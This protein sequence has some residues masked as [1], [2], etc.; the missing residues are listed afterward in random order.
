MPKLT[1]S[2]VKSVALPPGKN[3]L[4]F[5]DDELT[6]F[7]LRLSAR[8]K[9]F[10]IQ[11]R[12]GRRVLKRKIG[13]YG[14]LTVDQARKG[15]LLLKAQLLDGKD[16]YQERKQGP[17]NATLEHLFDEY[18]KE[19]RHRSATLRSIE[20]AKKSFGTLEGQAFRTKPDGRSLDRIDVVKVTLPSWLKRSYR[21]ITQDEVL[22]RFDIVTRMLPKR[23]LSKVPRPI[24]RTANQHFKY[25]QA[26]YNYAISKYRL[27]PTAFVNPVAILKTARR[28]DRMNRRS[29]FLD[30][31]KP[32][33]AKWWWACESVEPRVVS[34]YILFSLVTASRS[35]ESAT[36]RWQDVDLEKARMIFRNTKNGQDYMFPIAPL[37]RAILERRL[38]EKMNDFVFGYADSRTG[39]VVCPPHHHI[40]VIRAECGEEWSMHDLRRTFTTS[41]TAL[42]VHAFTISHL[43]K[44]SSNN[45]MTLSYSP[46]TQQQLFE[47]LEK[48]ERHMLER[49]NAVP[50]LILSFGTVQGH[51][52]ALA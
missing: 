26:A 16:P 12:L 40:K 46:P 15:A 44:H 11:M 9:V 18:A 42:G 41:M 37:A 34:D 23:R 4:F 5:M 19:V 47:A 14:V 45:S 52:E 50:N 8:K 30:T 20:K 51:E 27:S 10:Y 1:Q 25:L 24:T 6:G 17:S 22:A 13:E 29:G 31:T 32:S 48:L 49:V 43:M 38:G 21:S 28:W 7:G 39:R 3:Q 2:F 33:F 35:I 36:L